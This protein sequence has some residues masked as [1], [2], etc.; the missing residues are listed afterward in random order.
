M[1]F[2]KQ[3]CDID[4]MEQGRVFPE[5]TAIKWLA[6]I[7]LPRHCQ[8]CTQSISR[9]SREM[10]DHFPGT[11]QSCERVSYKFGWREETR[12]PHIPPSCRDRSSVWQAEQSASL[13]HW[14]CS[15]PELKA[16]KAYPGRRRRIRYISAFLLIQIQCFK[17]LSPR[18]DV[19]LFTIIKI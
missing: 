13:T 2:N 8:V 1:H 4:D 6:A 17:S 14:P 9:L 10:T 18:H 15:I 11:H 7:H 3:K 12:S 16:A 19:T 5:V